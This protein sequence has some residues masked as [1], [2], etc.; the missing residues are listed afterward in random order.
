MF[1]DSRYFYIQINNFEYECIKN[2]L[3]FSILSVEDNITI[4]VA[5]C[6]KVLYDDEMIECLCKLIEY[7]TNKNDITI[8][9]LIL[10]LT[11]NNNDGTL[12]KNEKILKLFKKIL[13]NGEQN[14]KNRVNYI[15]SFYKD[16]YN[17][18]YF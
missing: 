4:L 7:F 9:I 1:S 5:K 2:F 13:I 12:F 8:D 15:F 10:A 14:S 6:I 3:I 16:N 11:N 18:N 17:K